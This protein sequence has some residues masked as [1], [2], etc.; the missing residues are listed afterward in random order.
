ML[1]GL[2]QVCS[3]STLAGIEIEPLEDWVRAYL[4]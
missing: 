2:E 4:P 3:R 1:T